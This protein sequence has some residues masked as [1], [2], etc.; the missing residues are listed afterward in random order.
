MTAQQAWNLIG[1]LSSTSKMP[2]FGYSIPAKNCKTGAKLQKQK[3]NNT[4]CSG[5]YALRGNY[6]FPAIQAVLKK[7]LKSISNPLWVEAMA[8]AI[9]SNDSTGYF[10]WHDSGDLQSVSHLAKT[11]Q[12]AVKLPKVKFWLPTREYAIV[13]EY[14]KNNFI[15][16]NLTVRL[17]AHIIDGPMPLALASQTGCGVSGV[18]RVASNCPA[19]SQGNRCLTCRACWDSK[20]P[21]IYIK[22]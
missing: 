4:V 3:K 15:P 11:C 1:G 17:S 6:R 14:C 19:P 8:L 13:R 16:P 7:R 10:R 12:V 9:S 2:C 22:H 5:C 18:S 21:V 20:E